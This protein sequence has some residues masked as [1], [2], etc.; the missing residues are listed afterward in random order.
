MRIARERGNR[1]ISHWGFSGGAGNNQNRFFEMIQ[2]KVKGNRPKPLSGLGSCSLFFNAFFV[3][4][5]FS[6]P[7]ILCLVLYW[8]FPCHF[9][10]FGTL[11]VR[12]SVSF[13]I[14]VKH[15]WTGEK[16]LSKTTCKFWY[17]QV[18]AW[19]CFCKKIPICL[20]H[21]I[22]AGLISFHSFASSFCRLCLLFLFLDTWFVIKSSF[23]YFWKKT[24]L[25]QFSF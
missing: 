18:F 11:A 23:L 17:C 2:G 12:L 3:F 4:L 20:K 10:R 7:G 15:L 8:D 14:C 5:A 22:K 19:I 24:F 16:I 9:L 1:C 6:F 25:G 13:H 21:V